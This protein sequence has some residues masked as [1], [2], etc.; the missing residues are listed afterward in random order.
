MTEI[1]LLKII[2]NAKTNAIVGCMA[3]GT[4]KIRLNAKPIEGRANEALIIF[5]CDRLGV[6]RS[7]IS[8]ITGVRSQ[9]KRV[10]I[11][12][13]HEKINWEKLSH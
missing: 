5:L 13:I 6:S 8:I 2:P 3:D 7:Q 11:S 1:V 4:V 10:Q 9:R 12:G